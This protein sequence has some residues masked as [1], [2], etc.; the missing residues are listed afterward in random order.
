V[1]Y[2]LLERLAL[3]RISPTVKGLLDPDQ[4]GFRKGRSTCDQVAALT[5][6]IENGFQQNLT[7]GAIFLDLTAAYDTVWHTGLLY[8]LSKSMPSLVYLTGG[9]AAS[10][11][12]FQDAHG[13]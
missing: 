9:S 11:A 10:R 12:T 7:T 5:T 8:K 13:Q 4:A 3:Q 6:F 2:N 1:C